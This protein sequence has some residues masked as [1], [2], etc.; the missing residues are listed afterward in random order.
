MS[1]ESTDL[2]DVLNPPR[3]DGCLPAVL[4]PGQLAL[5]ELPRVGPLDLYAALLA[6]ATKPTTRRGR[7]NDVADL[8]RF[9][10]EAPH[11]SLKRESLAQAVAVIGSR[12][13]ALLI[14]DGSGQAN[15]LVTA[16]KA[17]LLELGQSPATINR[18]LSTIM[19]AAKLA[20]RFGLIDWSIEVEGLKAQAYRDTRGPGRA[21]WLRFESRARSDAKLCDEGKR[22]YA[23]IHLLYDLAL[24]RSTVAEL[25]L[26]HWDP[27]GGRLSVLGKG[28]LERTWK[29]VNAVVAGALEQWIEVRGREPGPLF[30]RMD[31]RAKSDGGTEKLR[32]SDNGIWDMLRSMSKAAGLK[33]PIRPHGLRHQAATRCAELSG[34]NVM[35]VQQLLD[36]RDPKTSQIYVDN[37]NTLQGK[38]VNL[39]ADD[40]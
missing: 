23:I 25:N 28:R 15:A 36:H 9:L 6:D 29:D 5:P 38:A 33:T 21:A 26:E 11:P 18:K 37:L 7:R 1:P 12:T 30:H 3:A 2:P 24:R 27:E 4:E 19:R 35:M 39:L 40:Y 8:A 16:Y 22:N 34:G 17:R 13:C 14:R 32:L 10:G 20:R 31:H